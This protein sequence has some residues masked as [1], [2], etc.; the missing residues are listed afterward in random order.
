MGQQ[1]SATQTHQPVNA[2][3][4]FNELLLA[5]FVVLVHVRHNFVVHELI[6]HGNIDKKA[7]HVCTLLQLREL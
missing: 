1:S 5:L 7:G 2:F 3:M 6:W 4:N